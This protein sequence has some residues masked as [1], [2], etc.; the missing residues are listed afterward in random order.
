MYTGSADFTV[1]APRYWNLLSQSHHLPGKNSAQFSAAVAI[2]TVPI[3]I[4]PGTHYYWVDRGSMDSKL[5]QGF[6]T[7]PTLPELNPRPLDLGSNALT[8]RQLAPHARDDFSELILT[9]FSQ[10]NNTDPNFTCCFRICSSTI[11]R[12]EKHKGI[13]INAQFFQRLQDL[14]HSIVKLTYSISISVK[15]ALV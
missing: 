4:P 15:R 3:F 11:I 13:I 2:Q 12:G 14:S 5:A 1:I 6:Y 7:W 10:Q 8:T 9:C